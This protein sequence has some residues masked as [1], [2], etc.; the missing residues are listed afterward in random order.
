ME[1]PWTGRINTYHAS[2]AERI[3]IGY[4]SLAP[5]ADVVRWLEKN[6]QKPEM[7]SDGGAGDDEAPV[8]LL[9]F[10]LYRRNDTLIDWGLAKHG[11]RSN[12]IQLVY[13]RGTPAVK[14]AAL[15]NPQRGIKIAQCVDIII[16]GRRQY[17]HALLKNPY[18]SIS[19][20]KKII[21]SPKFFLCNHE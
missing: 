18:I 10:M 14:L 16:S 21:R 5:A 6:Y 3:D 8:K 12:I 11:R 20:L 19:F 1:F 4:V 13:N 17:I 9:E 15:S 7:N 2:V